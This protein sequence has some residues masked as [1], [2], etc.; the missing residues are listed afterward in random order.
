MKPEKGGTKSIVKMDSKI[1][2]TLEVSNTMRSTEFQ[3][4]S[5]VST[6]VSVVAVLAIGVLVFVCVVPFSLTNTVFRLFPV[7]TFEFFELRISNS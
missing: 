2:L 6:V 7:D 3:G 4:I 1:V 5:V